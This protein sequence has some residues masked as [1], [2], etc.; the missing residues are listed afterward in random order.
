MLEP[1]QHLTQ[2]SMP[3]VVGDGGV[4][5]GLS[6]VS[7]GPG[8]CDA[9][10]IAHC[11]SLQSFGCLLVLAADS[12][13]VIAAGANT[14]DFLGLEPQAVL[15]AELGTL[16]PAGD[17][18][19]V[20]CVR[21]TQSEPETFCPEAF[22]APPQPQLPDLALS[23]R[24]T[25]WQGMLLL[26]IEPDVPLAT[27]TQ[28]G[29]CDPGAL[30]REL[31]AA[32]DIDILCSR[33]ARALRRFTG[34]ERVLVYR[35]EPDWDGTVIAEDLAPST[36][37][38]V[39]GLRYAAADIPSRAR[40]LYTATPLRYAPIRDHAEIPLLAA[41]E[42]PTSIDI[43]AAQLRA[44]HPT[45]R[46][47]L[48]QLGV[49]ASLSLS[50]VCD[51]HLWGLVIC[52]H[53]RPHAISMALRQR[54]AELAA[55]VSARIALL[56]QRIQLQAREQGVA[57]IN[58]IIGRLDIRKPFPQGFVGNEAL[59]RGLFAADAVQIFHRDAPLL[60][61]GALDLDAAEQ[62][63]L[64]HFLRKRGGGVWSTDCLSCEFEP[65]AA[66]PE[67]LAGI[68]AIFIG[69]TEDYVM[70]FGRR[71]TRF[72][73]RWGARPAA[74][75]PAADDTSPWSTR[76]FEPW[77]EERIHHAPPWTR[78]ELGTAEALRNLTQE[79]IV[80][81]AAHFEV[82][83]LRDSLTGLPNRERF[84]QILATTIEQAET[85]GGVFGI[86]LLDIDHF[87]SVNDTLGHDKGDI[88]LAAAAKRILAVLPEGAV[89][90]RLGGDEFALL[91]PSGHED[92][93]DAMPERV[94][95][96]FRTPISVDDDR[97][98]VSVSMGVTLGHGASQ[99][100][101]LL[102]QAD[103]AL[104]QAKDA[105]R[106]C[107]RAF[108]SGLQ[109]R[110]LV[111]LEI[112]REILGRSPKTAIEILLQPQVPIATRRPEPRFEVLAR[113]RTTEGRLLQPLEFIDAAQQ[114]GLMRAVTEAVLARSLLVL[115]EHPGAS[116]AD[117]VLAVNVTAADLE[118]RWFARSLLQAL[119]EANVAPA[120]LELE[121]AESVLLRITPSVRESLR[122]LSD[123]GIGI[124]LD[125]FGSGFSSMAH[126]RELNI[127]T[128]KVD[129]D[130]VRGVTA[131]QDRRLVAGIVA[132]AHSLG[133]RVVA[134]GV[135]RVTE[136]EVL[137]RLGCDWGQGY[138]WSEP[139]TPADAFDGNWRP[140]QRS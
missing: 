112:A 23:L 55:L 64:L 31:L 97:F 60:E 77:E 9:Q 47:Y 72:K 65:A 84:R 89:V 75:A 104:Y 41:R 81:S 123:G 126:L 34:F 52:H 99:G 90:A 82:L 121:I 54:L 78:S 56:E 15:G 44:L 108:D 98:A 117:P 10:P 134:E 57:A 74:L 42:V 30:G 4:D 76:R 91:L 53:R 51:G 70:L 37:P 103:M 120:R 36:L 113:W 131:E 24:L 6:M 128:L 136:L 39:R 133:K 80:A 22:S 67:R 12:L 27:A 40:A 68:I 26:E 127:S 19:L 105:G 33:L 73:V 95:A 140:A 7:R 109:Q 20:A 5:T 62:R 119:A 94:V 35:F 107:V 129:R 11:A 118:A 49:N 96:A 46:A 132:M 45:H 28:A 50:I 122:Q 88:L 110:A 115:R 130:F 138:L 61:E 58:A 137:R 14:K 101:E 69:P 21:E 85:T 48:E 63:A 83:A 124:A 102:K 17:G 16:L 13:R 139:L 100:T 32:A 1:L 93:L 86:G 87:K 18:G 106:D 135:E 43:G 29:A 3:D 114:N 125:D 8:R 79:V 71:R 116:G 59:L 38:S 2:C 111:R 66:Y 92:A 25:P